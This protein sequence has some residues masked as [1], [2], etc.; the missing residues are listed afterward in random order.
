MKLPRHPFNHYEL[1]FQPNSKH[2]QKDDA[3]HARD[4][5]YSLNN[6][7]RLREVVLP[8]N[9]DSTNHKEGLTLLSTS[10]NSALL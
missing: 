8:H 9:P 7:V 2:A 3:S 4:D 10:S 6:S 5:E 1:E